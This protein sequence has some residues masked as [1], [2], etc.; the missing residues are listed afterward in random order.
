MLAAIASQTQPKGPEKGEDQ[1]RPSFWEIPYIEVLQ[2]SIT[3]LK[4]AL[5]LQCRFA[6]AQMSL[7][8]CPIYPV[9]AEGRVFA[10]PS[11]DCSRGWC[12]RALPIGSGGARVSAGGASVLLPG[13]A[14]E[15]RARHHCST[16]GSAR[17]V[18]HATVSSQLLCALRIP[19][20]GV[21]SQPCFR[22]SPRQALTLFYVGGA[23]STS[24]L[25]S[26]QRKD[27]EGDACWHR[28]CVDL[29]GR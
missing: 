24:S 15:A 17:L 16:P 22:M 2:L 3:N 26:C 6:G 10:R 19:S 21:E 8:P 11:L 7:E 12:H 28:Y 18:Q 13:G 1:S 5:N 29:R 14:S 9:Q 27:G 20:Q 25:L 4:G 23:S